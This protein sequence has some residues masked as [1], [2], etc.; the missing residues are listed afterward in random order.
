MP[1]LY[2][3]LNCTFVILH[4]CQENGTSSELTTVPEIRIE[5]AAA[6]PLTNRSSILSEVSDTD[7]HGSEESNGSSRRSS[8]DIPR[9][10]LANGRISEST[11]HQ[12]EVGRLSACVTLRILCG[13]L[14]RLVD[15]LEHCDRLDVAYAASLFLLI[16]FA[17]KYR[18]IH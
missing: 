3:T 2:D 7:Y 13:L 17:P 5:E 18:V 4:A 10:Q 8:I 15:R 14:T 1:V 11:V 9:Y 6:S 12:S 16:V